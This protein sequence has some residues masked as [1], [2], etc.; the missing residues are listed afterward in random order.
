MALTR[1]ALYNLAL[2]QVLGERPLDSLSEDSHPKRVF[3]A[4]WTA[5]NGDNPYV[6]SCLEQGYWNFAVRTVKIDADDSVDTQ[7]GYQYAFAKPS[8]FVKLVSIA[9]DEY[10]RTVLNDFENETDRFYADIDPIYLRFISDDDDYG[11]N[12]SLWPQSFMTWVAHDL[13]FRGAPMIKG[14]LDLERLEKRARAT[15]KIAK[16]ND[17][18]Q[19]PTRFQPEGSWSMARHGRRGAG[20]RRDGGSRSTLIG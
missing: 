16:S 7:F 11:G 4:I 1:L 17:A 20:T 2:V 10:F 13:A 14:S 5:G 18:Q 8:D 9:S 6:R 3:D 19:E 12:L 15:L